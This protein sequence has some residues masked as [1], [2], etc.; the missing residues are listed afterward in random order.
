MPRF[1]FG[2]YSGEIQR[3]TKKVSGGR[4]ELGATKEQCLVHGPYLIM[5]TIVNGSY[6]SHGY[7]C[8]YGCTPAVYRV[9]KM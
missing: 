4:Q 5:L 7:S 1:L 8:V 9:K 3:A 6:E 2:E